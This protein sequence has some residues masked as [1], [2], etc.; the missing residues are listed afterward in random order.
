MLFLQRYEGLL[1]ACVVLYLPVQVLFAALLDLPAPLVNHTF[2]LFVDSLVDHFSPQVIILKAFGV[3]SYDLQ[4]LY[5]VRLDLLPKVLLLG[6][7]E[8]FDSFVLIVMFLHLSDRL[9]HTIVIS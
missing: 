9:H 5:I 2:D 6:F 3:V 1:H 4:I 8:A 7:Y